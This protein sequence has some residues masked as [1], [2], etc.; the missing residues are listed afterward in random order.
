MMRAVLATLVLVAA[1]V[2]ANVGAQSYPSRPIRAIVGFAPGGATDIL[3][4][5]I[6]QKLTESLG[7]QVIVDNRAGGGGVIAAITARDAPPDGYT[8]FFGTIST[9]AANVATNPKL[10]Y[11]PLRDYAPV[12]LTASNPYFLVVHPSVPAKS[13]AEFIAL[14]R[15]RPGQLNFA[16]SGTG[17][18][19]HLA[20]EYFRSMAKIDMVHVPYKGAAPSMTE[21]IAGQVQMTLA[22]PAVS[23]APAKAGRLR[24]LGVSSIKRLVSWPDAPPIAEAVPGYESASW[25]GVVLPAKA[26]RPIID[27]LHRDIVVALR[28]PEIERRLLADGSEIGGGSPEAFGAYIRS[29][30]AKWTRVVKEAGIKVE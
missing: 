3:A 30:I 1:V 2:A 8:I 4:R 7:Q 25:Q 19:A 13:T 9:L 11:D 16:S 24:I 21:L 23:L 17:G 12:T 20:L 6:G 14:A 29:E 10:P 26:P 28:S 18:G 22:Q 27:R 5:Q 15:A